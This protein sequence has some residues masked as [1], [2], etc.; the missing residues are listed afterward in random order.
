MTDFSY[1]IEIHTWSPHQVRAPLSTEPVKAA[2]CS[3]QGP[4][5][6]LLWVK[7]PQSSPVTHVEPTARHHKVTPNDTET[8]CKLHRSLGGKKASSR[9]GNARGGAY[10]R[11]GGGGSC[12]L[13]D[14]ISRERLRLAT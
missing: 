6:L 4:S 8:G 9:V 3:R 10:F 5:V 13:V 11:E 14:K 12:I 2:L 1:R 7:L